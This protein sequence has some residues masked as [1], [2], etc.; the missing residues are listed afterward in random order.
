VAQTPPTEPPTP[1]PAP[2]PLGL[3]A[4]LRADDVSARLQ[5]LESERRALLPILR[6]LRARERAALRAQEV[7]RA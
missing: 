6:S 7:T 3:L 1:V 2:D 4:Q 5:A